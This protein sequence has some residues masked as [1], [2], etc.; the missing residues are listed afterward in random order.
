MLPAAVIVAEEPPNAPALLYWMSLLAPPGVPPPLETVDQ[1][2]T[3]VPFV[4]STWPDAPGLG[5][6]MRF[7]FWV[8][9]EKIEV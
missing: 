2:V 7:Q 5:G 9:P 4:V 6:R 8:A 3:P 1:Y